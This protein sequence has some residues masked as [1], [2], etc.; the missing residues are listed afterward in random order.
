M[1][2]HFLVTNSL[3]QFP[4]P[5]GLVCVILEG[6]PHRVCKVTDQA[7]IQ[8]RMGTVTINVMTISQYNPN[9]MSP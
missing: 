6:I 8:V 3:L 7:W 4:L 5:M 1:A 2:A 9:K